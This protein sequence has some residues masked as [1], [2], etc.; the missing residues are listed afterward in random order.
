MKF[1]SNRE[2]LLAA[3]EEFSNPLNEC[4]SNLMNIVPK[5]VWGED[6]SESARNAKSI[7][8]AQSSTFTQDWLISRTKSSHDN[9][10]HT[11]LPLFRQNT[12]SNI[13]SRQKKNLKLMNDDC[14]L[15]SRLYIACQTRAGDLDNFFAQENHSF[16]FN[17]G[18]WQLMQVF[19]IPLYFMLNIYRRTTI[20]SP[21]C[22]WNRNRWCSNGPHKLS[23]VFHQDIRWILWSSGR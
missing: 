2:S 16:R 22:Q 17:L 11:N 1:K 3:F 7:G 19:E 5:D 13:T 14:R 21:S 6:A 10:A 12:A 8:Y 9:I 15:F 20:W 23:W 18:V 4:E